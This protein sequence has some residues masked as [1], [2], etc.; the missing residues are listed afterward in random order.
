[1]TVL[2][3]LKKQ[4]DPTRPTWF[5]TPV[6]LRRVIGVNDDW[7]PKV[8]VQTKDGGTAHFLALLDTELV[9]LEDC[10]GCGHVHTR[11]CVCSDPL[12]CGDSGIDD[13]HICD[14]C[15]HYE[16]V[17]ELPASWLI[18]GKNHCER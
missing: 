12:P 14:A 9:Q 10:L 3:Y 15:V 11:C 1:M 18:L 16:V 5:Q 17:D 4:F 8:I 13:D 7:L 6:G 2:D